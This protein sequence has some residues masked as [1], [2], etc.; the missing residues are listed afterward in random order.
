MVH[1]FPCEPF[2]KYDIFVTRYFMHLVLSQHD[3]VALWQMGVFHNIQHLWGLECLCTN[4]QYQVGQNLKQISS[5]HFLY[6]NLESQKWNPFLSSATPHFVC[7]HNLSYNAAH[8]VAL[9]HLTTCKFKI[10]ICYFSLHISKGE[11]L[12]ISCWIIYMEEPWW[13]HKSIAVHVSTPF[14]QLESDF[15][16]MEKETEFNAIIQIAPENSTLVTQVHS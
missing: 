14:I 4:K 9:F 16:I 5:E 15:V 8:P 10:S 11:T 3:K 2:A 7:T 1:N 6:T 12:D 13:Y